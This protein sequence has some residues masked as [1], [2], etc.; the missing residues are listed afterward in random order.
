M[1]SWEQHHSVLK[2]PGQEGDGREGDLGPCHSREVVRWIQY[3]L[4]DL[5]PPLLLSVVDVTILMQSCHIPADFSIETS[6]PHL[7][8]SS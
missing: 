2:G 1:G 4:L 3:L 5:L 8:D 7:I 6:M